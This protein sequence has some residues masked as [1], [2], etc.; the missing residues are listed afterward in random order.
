MKT[1]GAALQVG[2]TPGQLVLTE[3]HSLRILFVGCMGRSSRSLMAA[4]AMSELGH[5]VHTI[6]SEPVDGQGERIYPQDLKF[7]A[8]SKLG[9]PPDRQGANKQALACL[10]SERFDILWI[11]K[12]LCVRPKLLQFARYSNPNIRIVF[13]SEDDMHARHNQSVWFRQALPFYDIVFT[14]KSYNAHPDELPALGARR[15]V[16]IDK[17]FDRHLHKPV[18]VTDEDRQ[19]L[20]ATVGFVGTYERERAEL[21]LRLAES[22]VPVRVWGSHWGNWVDRHSLMRVEDK[23]LNASDYVKAIAC[24][25]INLGFLRRQ[26]RDLQT[27]RSIEIPACGAFML[28]ERSSEHLRLFE[29]GR[30]AE[31]FDDFN[32]LKHKVGHFLHSDC[33]RQSIAERGRLRCIQ[34]GYSFHERLQT[35]LKIVGESSS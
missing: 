17:C 18:P 26:N 12:S 32:E 10:A 5:D 8:L 27:D 3:P 14:H 19:R 4:R 33:E 30:E 24:T 28:A 34:D 23:I 16:M 25:D 9:Y 7:R 29:E 1:L 11:S 31:F 21:I 15:V 13:H 2:T 22:G 20:G 6:Q 35:M